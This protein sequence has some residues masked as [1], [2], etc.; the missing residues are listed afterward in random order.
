MYCFWDMVHDGWRAW[1]TDGQTD[2]QANGKSVTE[3]GTTPKN[4]S[5]WK[6]IVNT[7]SFSCNSL[8]LLRK[9]HCKSSS[10][11]LVFFLPVCLAQRILS[12]VVFRSFPKSCESAILSQ[13]LKLITESIYSTE[14]L[15]KRFVACRKWAWKIESL[16]GVKYTQCE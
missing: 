3:V 15:Y 14:C 4:C 16:Q 12:Q 8:A 10:S 11:S 7:L 13:L 1:R 2:R 9:I 5:W 6:Q